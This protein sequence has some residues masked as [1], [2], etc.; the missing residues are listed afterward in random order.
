MNLSQEGS[1]RTLAVQIKDEIE[2][3]KMYTWH[4]LDTPGYQGKEG[5]TKWL[6]QQ[7]KKRDNKGRNIV[8]IEKTRRLRQ[9]SKNI[10][11]M[12]IAIDKNET[13][14]SAGSWKSSA[15]SVEEEWKNR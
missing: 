8:R 12:V 5:Q 15:K 10:E 2:K 11:D 4:T 6:Q 13:G 7:D 1:S 9:I 3:L 14:K